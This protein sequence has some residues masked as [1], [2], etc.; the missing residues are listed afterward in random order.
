MF[1]KGHPVGIKEMTIKTVLR[2]YLTST[3]T[4]KIKPT[5]AGEDVGSEGQALHAAGE[6]WHSHDNDQHRD[7]P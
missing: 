3:I 6:V 5:D 2:F 4:K 1:E 7:S